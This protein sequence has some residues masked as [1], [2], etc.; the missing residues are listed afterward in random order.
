[1]LSLPIPARREDTVAQGDFRRWI[2]EHV[3]RWFAFTQRLGLG[4][5]R[6]EDIMLVTGCHRAKTW[7]NGAFSEGQG[8]VEASFSVQI[9]SAAA[10]VGIE[11]QRSCEHIHGAVLNH[12]PNGIVRRT[13]SA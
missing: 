13:H 12:G 3:D 10:G 8:G 11:W 7:A 6:M 1:M 4:L 9:T 5:D 2:V